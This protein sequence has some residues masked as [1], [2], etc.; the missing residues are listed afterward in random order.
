[1]SDERPLWAHQ[2][3]CIERAKDQGHFGLFFEMGTGKT[4]TTIELIKDKLAKHRQMLPTLILAPSVVT[5]NWKA[6]LAKFSDINPAHILVLHGTA[7]QRRQMLERTPNYFVVITNYEALLMDMVYSALKAWGPEIIVADESHRIKN[8]KAHRTKR[9]LG[10]SITAKY[11]YILSG[12]P[13]T[14]NEADLFSQFL[15]MDG[16]QTFGKSFFTFRNNWFT[17]ANRMIRARNPAVMWPNWQPKAHKKKEFTDKVMAKAMS[18]T[19]DECLDLPPYTQ[20]TLEVGM[21][22]DQARAYK[23]MKDDFIAYVKSS[24]FVADQAVTKAMRLNQ[25]AS[26]FIMN[27]DGETVVFKNTPKEKALIDLI[28]SARGKVVVWAAWRSNQKSIGD[29]LTKHNIEH[30]ELLGDSGA[31]QR[32]D[33]LRDFADNP[34]V[35]VMLASQAAAGVGIS[36]VAANT[37]IYFSRNFSF[38]ADAQSA[39]RIHRGGSEIHT[40]V[41]RIDLVVPDTI[42]VS[43]L[44]SLAKKE[45]LKDSIINGHLR[46]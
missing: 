44:E 5:F 27:P 2:Q 8:H 40:N 18:V 20:T 46:V 3:E 11:K 10:L 31:K 38:E 16:G 39:A 17:D 21:A 45:E 30:R 7:L 43:C 13:I 28:E 12:T 42:D 9:L 22:P 34:N 23:S 4:R 1:M 14:N 24:A 37:A 33:A 41:Y 25:I 36:L 6:E 35:K 15:F 29:L 26:G 32:D 19:K